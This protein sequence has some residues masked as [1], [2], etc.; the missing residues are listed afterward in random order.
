MAFS[1]VHVLDYI[2]SCVIAHSLST[3]TKY[4]I[5]NDYRT[6]LYKSCHNCLFIWSYIYTYVQ[7][8]CILFLKYSKMYVAFF[9]T[10]LSYTGYWP[11][12]L[13]LLSITSPYLSCINSFFVKKRPLLPFGVSGVYFQL[14]YYFSLSPSLWEEKRGERNFE[15]KW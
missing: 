5:K 1:F 12:C 15:W 6:G 13:V 4:L 11:F 7:I 8:W 3:Q 2:Q 10:W 14:F 9:A